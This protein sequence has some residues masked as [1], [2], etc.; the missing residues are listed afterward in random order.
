MRQSAW[1]LRSRL[2]WLLVGAAVVAWIASSV[3]LYRSSLAQTDR[4]FD[5][6]LV[7]TAHA[8]LALVAREL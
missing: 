7:E 5:A 3:W 2:T 4:L 1:S 6:A 8:V